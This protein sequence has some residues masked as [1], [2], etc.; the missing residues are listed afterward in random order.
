MSRR[1]TWSELRDVTARLVAVL[2][3][4]HV[5]GRR[6]KAVASDLFVRGGLTGPVAENYG[7]CE[8]FLTNNRAVRWQDEMSSFLAAGAVTLTGVKKAGSRSEA[9]TAFLAQQ[10]G[11]K[12]A[13]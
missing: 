6:G 13:S 1:G 7:D 3:M 2:G 10:R 12:K 11:I 9:V 8:A 4:F 5:P